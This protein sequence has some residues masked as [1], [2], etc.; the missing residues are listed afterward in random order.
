M[1]LREWQS[2]LQESVLTETDLL[3]DLLKPSE[4]DRATRLG[5]Y[6]NAYV[7]RLNEALLCNYPAVHQILGDD[8]FYAMTESYLQLYPS[9]D[10]SIR[11]FGGHLAKFLA[12][13][14][15][16]TSLPALAELAHFEWALRHTVDAADALV[17]TVEALQLIPAES[18]SDLKFELHPSLSLLMMEWNVTQI[19]RALTKDEE[20]PEPSRAPAHWLVYR[21][22]DLSSVWRSASEIEVVVIKA[23][24]AG[25]SFAELCVIA[26]DY[27]EDVDSVPAV[28][29]STLKGFVEQGLLTLPDA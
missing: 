17:V 5:I 28:V 3:G 9:T 1:Q 27:I 7:A 16:Y 22:E 4:L 19:W 29:A 15:P 21:Q 24:A 6:T 18:W 14:E 10:A 12:N 11:W 8:D 2:A 20:P 23:I 25:N 26:A 13:E